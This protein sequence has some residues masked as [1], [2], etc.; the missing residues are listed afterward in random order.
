MAKNDKKK[1]KSYNDIIGFRESTDNYK[2]INDIGY[3]GRYQMGNATLQDLGYTK[4]R[5]KGVSQKEWLSNPK[6]WK[7]KDGIKNLDNFLSN[8]KVQDKAQ[9]RWNKIIDSRL[10]NNGIEKYYGKTVGGVKIT[11]EGARAAAHLIGPTGFMKGLKSGSLD[12]MKDAYGTK[13]LE[14]MEMFQDFTPPTA[15]AS[16]DGLIDIDTMSAPMA[17]FMSTAVASDQVPTKPLYQRDKNATPEQKLQDL[18]DRGY[19]RE[20]IL[21]EMGRLSAPG[22]DQKMLPFRGTLAQQFNKIFPEATT[23]PEEEKKA[24]VQNLAQ[25]TLVDPN[26]RK[27]P[28]RSTPPTRT[29]RTFPSTESKSPSPTQPVQKEPLFG[30]EPIGKSPKT[31]PNPFA[32]IQSQISKGQDPLA[33]AMPATPQPTVTPVNNTGRTPRDLT[34]TGPRQAPVRT[35]RDGSTPLKDGWKGTAYKVGRDI[36]NEKEAAESMTAMGNAL[37]RNANP[38]TIGNG[39]VKEV[40]AAGDPEDA[41][42][43]EALKSENLVKTDLLHSQESIKNSHDKW[44]SQAVPEL[45]NSGFT[46]EQIMKELETQKGMLSPYA[47]QSAVKSVQGLE[48]SAPYEKVKDSQIDAM[49]KTNENLANNVDDI[50]ANGNKLSQMTQNPTEDDL[51]KQRIQEGAGKLNTKANVPLNWYESPSFNRALVT[52]GMNLLGGKGYADSFTAAAGAY[53]QEYG[54]E[55]RQSYFDELVSQGYPEYQ[56]AQW[57]E[58]GTTKLDRGKPVESWSAPYIVGDKYVQRNTSTGEYRNVS[59]IPKGY[60][61]DASGNLIKAPEGP[62]D[63]TEGDK[64]TQG[65]YARAHD[66][67]RAY[68]DYVGKNPVDLSGGTLSK[69]AD[70]ATIDM[71]FSGDS[72]KETLAKGVNPDVASVITMERNIVAPILRKES[73]AAISAQ[74]WKT[75]ASQLFPRPGD[76]PEDIDRK[77]RYREITIQ[78]LKAGYNP[79]MRAALDGV[80]NGSYKDMRSE[81]GMVYVLDDQGKWHKV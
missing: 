55:K 16:T 78:G 39:I 41:A 20:D 26:A 8:S 51:I 37:G 62:A 18:K 67:N 1:P 12:K 22:S 25:E 66:A 50:D 6:A 9:D 48:Q 17:P 43:M 2:A 28:D 74:E 3:V 63:L 34:P 75:Y 19:T 35:A 70:A 13:P 81:S 69:L 33:G 77:N 56:V 52:F 79:D 53:D 27:A 57:V 54:K 7:G 45:Y 15:R 71:M 24:E 21:Q 42:M 10:K 73:G 38:F 76:S 64:L 14:Y 58:D 46:R 23:N 72:I 5:P 30:T 61:S 65:F 80:I 4:P 44:W 31:V 59:G 36:R 49:K 11:P 29:A 47:Y 32:E 60:S 40:A 68:Q